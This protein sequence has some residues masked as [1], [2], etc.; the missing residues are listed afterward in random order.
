M[1][2]IVY[3]IICSRSFLAFYATGCFHL[4]FFLI[5]SDVA[6]L[7]AAVTKFS[8]K[9]RCSLAFFTPSRSLL[10]SR[11][12]PNISFGVRLFYWKYP[13]IFG[14]IVHVS[15]INNIFVRHVFF[16]LYVPLN[17][18]FSARPM[19]YDSNVF[20]KES[21]IRWIIDTLKIVMHFFFHCGLMKPKINK[22]TIE[23]FDL[24][25]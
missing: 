6:T 9:I 15:I 7:T 1:F 17:I 21:G 25:H 14:Y 23:T 8:W 10:Q 5:Q 4:M 20:N 2:C 16:V 24:L 13:M 22:Y 12:L 18:P 11:K 3:G 19:L